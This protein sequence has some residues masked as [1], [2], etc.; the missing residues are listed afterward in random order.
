MHKRA[1]AALAC[2]C[3]AAAGFAFS[4]GTD[5]RDRP[6]ASGFDFFVLALSWS[7]SY[8]A[9][10]GPR[11]NR[12]QCAPD[13]DHGLIVHGLWPQFERGYPEYCRLGEPDRVPDRLADSVSDIMP[14]RGLVGHQWRKHGSCTGL[15]QRDYLATTR[16]AFERI[17]V[18]AD[19][20][21]AEQAMRLDASAIEAAFTSANPGLRRDGIAIA[22]KEGMLS[23][24]RIC[25]TKDL[26]F[27]ACENLNRRECR[28]D[29]LAVPAAP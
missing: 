2:A 10:E 1:L 6:A 3:V 5:A 15:S 9:I 21:D 24:V 12:A 26:D 11:A 25:M 20:R 8:C 27:R 16:K 7:P 13:L 28:R 29:G 19:L 22:C 17:N 23:E 14:T 18:P 4:N